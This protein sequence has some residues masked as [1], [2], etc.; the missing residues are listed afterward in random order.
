MKKLDLFGLY[1]FG[2][3]LAPLASIKDGDRVTDRVLAL[4]FALLSLRAY[5]ADGSPFLPTARRA[6]SSLISAIE[7]AVPNIED[8]AAA[9]KD[10]Q[11]TFEWLGAH[12]IESALKALETVLP[13]DMPDISAYIVSQK[14]IYRTEDLIVRADQHFPA[15]VRKNIPSQAIQDL[16]EAGKCL[17]FEVP[18]ACAFHLWRA[19]E[20][21]MGAYYAKLSGSTFEKDKVTRNWAAYIQ[22]LNGKGADS[23]IT[24]F[25]DHIRDEY[26]NPQTHP[27]AMLEVNEAL[28]LFGVATSAIHQM[29]L[30]VQKP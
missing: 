8:L 16:I 30:A 29:I 19:V 25:L 20:T 9:L 24:K 17:A 1:S 18:T 28:G 27:E 23:N 22:A 3:V 10:E 4:Y 2:K 26:R 13:N 21:V 11:K 15:E 14:G 12:R 6:I 7:N 5:T